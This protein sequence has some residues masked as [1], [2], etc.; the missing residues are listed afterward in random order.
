MGAR[1]E[2]E[3]EKSDRRMSGLEGDPAEVGR[4]L[5]NDSVKNEDK[6]A[7]TSSQKRDEGEQEDGRRKEAGGSSGEEC[8]PLH[9]AEPLAP[10]NDILVTLAGALLGTGALLKGSLR[11]IHSGLN[12]GAFIPRST[13]VC[14]HSD[15]QSKNLKKGERKQQTR[16]MKAP[17]GQFVVE[18]VSEM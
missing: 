14:T 15:S 5:L 6:A 9:S 17:G 11:V 1:E 16:L 7:E 4:G 3:K 10:V 2:E 12:R 13:G 8:S 18:L